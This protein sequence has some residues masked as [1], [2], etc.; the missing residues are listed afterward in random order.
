[1]TKITIS[2]VWHEL[3]ANAAVASSNNIMYYYMLRA[4]WNIAN[5]GSTSQ[6]WR[7]NDL[8]LRGASFFMQLHRCTA[9]SSATSLLV[10]LACQRINFAA[11]Q[12]YELGKFGEQ[13]AQCT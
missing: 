2:A 7:R 9:S 13:R 3:D 4:F 1:M 11:V 5:C 12:T 6:Q 10:R 8:T